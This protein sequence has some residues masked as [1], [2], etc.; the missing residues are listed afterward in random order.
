MQNPNKPKELSTIV[1]KHRTVEAWAEIAIKEFQKALDKKKI[2]DTR[3]LFESFKNELRSSGGDVQSVILRF[4]MYGRFV[5]MGVGRGVKA[6][7]RKS[8]KANLIAAKRY[9]AN[10]SYN[11]RQPRRWYNKTKVSQ[12]LRL[13]EILIRDLGNEITTWIA[14]SFKGEI[15]VNA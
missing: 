1:A 15:D 8:N 4:A 12:T 5:D 2:H 7:E 13:Q 14:D 10:V 9:G 3:F 6:Y 11:R